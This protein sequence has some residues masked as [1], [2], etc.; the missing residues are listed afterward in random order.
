VKYK[1]VRDNNFYGRYESKEYTTIA[2]PQ[3]SAEKNN[4]TLDRKLK[5]IPQESK[6]MRIECATCKE[7]TIEALRLQKKNLDLELQLRKVK[8]ALLTK[9]IDISAIL[10]SSNAQ[11]S[12]L[13]WLSNR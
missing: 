4:M 8:H 5:A 13:E 9:N 1:S 7:K 6:I 12:M 2:E 11:N 10:P 3:Q